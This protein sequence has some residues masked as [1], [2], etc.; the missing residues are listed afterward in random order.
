[1]P[2]CK[3]VALFRLTSFGLFGVGLILKA[4][5]TSKNDNDNNNKCNKQLICIVY[6]LRIEFRIRQD[7]SQLINSRINHISALE[8]HLELAK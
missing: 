8:L 2:I 1:M 5:K 4:T 6:A 3:F 7:V